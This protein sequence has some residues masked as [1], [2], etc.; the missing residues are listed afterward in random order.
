MNIYEIDW[1]YSPTKEILNAISIAL[2]K[3]KKEV[4]PED[5]DEALEQLE[6]F[7]G[8]GFI[9]A[10]TYIEGSVA[11]I[12]KLTK[13]KPNKKN[14]LKNFNDSISGTAITKMQLCDA[15]AN[16]FKH[17]DG[18][19]NDW[20]L[21]SDGRIKP[22]VDTLGEV[23]ITQTTTYPCQ[24]AAKTLWSVNTPDL[25]VLLSMLVEWRGKAVAAYK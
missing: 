20:T 16:Y 3:I 14:L 7:L 12:S 18:W 13:T 1:R 11:D 25:E 6:S 2:V 4:L 23:G 5:V 21:I 8:V 9:V 22:T 24:E 17:H 15:V 10:Q 19:A